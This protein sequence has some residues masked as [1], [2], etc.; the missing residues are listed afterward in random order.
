M[1]TATDGTLL[2]GDYWNY[3]VHRFGTNGALLQTFS[4][5]G[6]GPGQNLAPHGLAVDPR[7]GSIYVADQNATEID[8]FDAAGNY[9]YSIRTFIFGVT[10]PNSYVTR[11]VVDSRGWVYAVNS[12]SLPSLDDFA[13]RVLVFDDQGKFQFA[14]GENGVQDHQFRLLRGIDIGLRGQ[15]YI[16]DAG[17]GRIKVFSPEGSFLRAFGS[18][19]SQPGQFGGDLRGIVVDENDGWVYVVDAAQNQIEKFTLAGRYLTT[20]GSEGRDLGQFLDGGREITV[21]PDN[22]VY[23]ADFGNNRVNVFRP[24]GKPLRELPAQPLQAPD[25][26]FNLAKDV[27]VNDSTGEVYVVDTYNH[28]IQRFSPTGAFLDTWGYRATNGPDAMNYPRGITVDQSTGDVWMSNTR[29]GEI[30]AY[31]AT[32]DYIREFWWYGFGGDNVAALPRGLWITDDGRLLVADGSNQRIKIS[33]HFGNLLQTLPCGLPGFAGAWNLQGCS[34]V[35][36]DDDGNIYATAVSENAI[37]K[38]EPD[39]TFIKKWGS[40]GNGPGQLDQPYD[41]D[42]YNG[43]LYVSDSKNNRI[44]VFDLDGNFVEAFGAKGS[45]HGRFAQPRGLDIDDAGYLYVADQLNERVEVFDLNG[46]IAGGSQ[47]R[48]PH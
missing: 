46:W 31:T 35:I 28:R 40:P 34:S 16:A 15:I 29:Q 47:T 19:G 6:K 27:A 9:L 13:Q 33:D 17:T 36:Q 20:F 24:W 30:K 1:A 25:G 42:I 3:R 45:A 7:D 14:F 37:Y 21:G 41:L 44:S 10:R 26:G 4:T 2:V 39:G 38:W 48:E 11:M 22:N 18:K 5:K 32:G 43:R 23:I 8:R 12:H